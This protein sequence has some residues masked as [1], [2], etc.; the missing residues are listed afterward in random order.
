MK[1][2]FSHLLLA[3]FVITAVFFNVSAPA[4]SAQTQSMTISQFVEL[5]ITIGAVPVDRVVA[6]RAMVAS[7]GNSSALAAPA[8]S[9]GTLPYLQVLTPNGGENWNL[10]AQLPY[11]I[12]WGS[13]SQVPVT[14]SLVPA[15]GE[16]CNL[17]SS[18]VTSIKGNNSYSVL[19][20]NA[21]CINLSLIHI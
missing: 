8:V 19:L 18:P 10:D 3:V 21:Q 12:T 15:K 13:T 2:Y 9:T 6:V 7:L 1:K 20:K 4:A 16:I 17:S 11:A 5:M 14:I